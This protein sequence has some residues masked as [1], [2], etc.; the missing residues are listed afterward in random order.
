MVDW[1]TTTVA[2]VQERFFLFWPPFLKKNQEM[3]PAETYFQDLAI[4]SR[5]SPVG[6]THERVMPCALA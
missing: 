3:N 6:A 5:V 1:W 2:L 4:S